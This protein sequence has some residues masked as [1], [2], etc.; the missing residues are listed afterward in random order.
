MENNKKCWRWAKSL[1]SDLPELIIEGEI[2]NESWWGDEITPKIFREEL[3]KYSPKDIIVRINSP[4]GDSFAGAAIY[5]ALKEYQGK[6]TAKIDGLA[7][8]A[9]S[10]IAMACDKVLISP[11]ATMM[12]HCA[13]TFA[14]GNAVDLQTYIEELKAVDDGMVTAYVSKTGKTRE[15]ILSLMKKETWFSAKEA[16]ENNFA[17]EVMDF[18]NEKKELVK[19]CLNSAINSFIAKVKNKSEVDKTRQEVIEYLKTI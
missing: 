17:D 18:D 16:V 12:I 9:A 10:W 4:G 3:N 15:E 19:N 5:T 13:W 11:C 8:S 2:S 7:A 6:T 1:T 14:A